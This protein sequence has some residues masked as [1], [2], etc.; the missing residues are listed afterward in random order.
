VTVLFAWQFFTVVTFI[1]GMGADMLWVNQDQSEIGIGNV[2]IKALEGFV[3]LMLMLT[4]YG[5]GLVYAY[6]LMSSLISDLL[7][8]LGANHVNDNDRLSTFVKA[9]LFDYYQSVQQKGMGFLDK[10]L[11]R[12]KAMSSL[13]GQ[14][15]ALQEKIRTYNNAYSSAKHQQ[16]G[17]EN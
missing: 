15:A 5:V 7:E 12:T 16:K 13:K 17:G 2:L 1:V 6:Q 11:G 4:V 8:K 14:E 10:H 9:M 3:F